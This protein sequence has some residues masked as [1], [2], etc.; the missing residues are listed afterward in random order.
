MV[1]IN[2]AGVGI[3]GV[4]FL[5]L[6]CAQRSVTMRVNISVSVGSSKFSVD[7]NPD[8]T[9]AELKE[10]LFSRTMPV[11]TLALMR[12]GRAG[13]CC[14]LDGRVR[15]ARMWSDLPRVR[16]HTGVRG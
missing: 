14:G 3:L 2:R 4:E 6:V 10:V 13:A 5:A 11:L 1:Q 16:T 9:V 15:R 8:A 12:T 7:I